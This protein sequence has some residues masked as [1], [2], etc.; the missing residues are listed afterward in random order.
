MST[1]NQWIIQRNPE[2]ADH[3]TLK[4][5]PAT[6]KHL[7]QMSKRTLLFSNFSQAILRGNKLWVVEQLQAAAKSVTKTFYPIIKDIPDLLKAEVSSRNCLVVKRSFSENTKHVLF[8]H[9]AQYKYDIQKL[10]AERVKHYDH[11]AVKMC[12]VQPRWFGVSYIKEMKEKGE[13]RV[14]FIGGK[15]LYMMAMRPLENNQ[16]LDVELVSWVTP[17]AYL[18]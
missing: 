3:M 17:L 14:Y 5:F 4:D 10:E 2:T 15:P 16:G 1:N 7:M 11:A 13:V 8:Q 18:S 6:V 9:N 12:G